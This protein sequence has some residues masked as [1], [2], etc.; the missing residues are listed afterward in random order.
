[1]SFDACLAENKEIY[2]RSSYIGTSDG[3]A[4]KPYKTIQKAVDISDSGDVIYIFGGLYRENIVIDKQVKIVGSIDGTETTIDP[5]SDERYLI[6]ITADEVTLE[7][8]A[9]REFPRNMTSPI[10]A[11]ICLKSDNNKIIG[12]Y[13]ND[14]DTY[15]IYIAASSNDNLISNNI[16]NNTKIGIYVISS[17]T[18]DIANNNIYNCSKYAIYIESSSGNNRVFGNNIYHSDSGIYSTLSD[19]INV[20]DNTIKYSNFYSIYIN[21]C[22]NATIKYNL[23]CNSTSYGVYLSSSSCIIQNNII[24]NNTRGICIDGDDNIVTKNDIY[25]N[26]GS[27]IYIISSGDDNTLYL[28]VIDNNAISAQDYGDNQWYYMFQGN[29]WSD[30]NNIDK[31]LDGIG[32]I[33]YTKNGVNDEYPLGFFLKPP[34]KPSDPTPE[35]FETGVG[36]RITLRVY[37]EDP[38]SDDLT[39]YFYRIIDEDPVLID[40]T[41]RNPVRYVRN[42]SYVECKFTLGFNATVVWYVV[43]DDGLLQNQSD[44]FVFSTITTPPDNAPP[45]ANP[46]GPYSAKINENVQFS[47]S[48]S[49]DPD[50]EIDFYRWNFGDGSSEIIEENPTHKYLSSMEYQVTLTVIDNN[51]SSA[52]ETAIVSVSTEFNDPPVAEISIQDTAYTGENILC[53]SSGTYDPDNDL[54]TYNWSFGNSET[55]NEASP[56]IVYSKKGSYVIELVVSDGEYSDSAQKVITIKE[57][58]SGLI[59]GFEILTLF[60]GLVIAIFIIK[61]RNG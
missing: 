59:P 54:L 51:G 23:I 43:V 42:D 30:Y 27:G 11:L 58:E 33:A 55:S 3:S 35:D 61:K 47:S 15:G 26:T 39:V 21:K 38:D 24:F 17:A 1:M 45:I 10:G 48:G 13:I 6:E 44:F 20:S 25:D 19:N 2:V 28:N 5:S 12:N 8:V 7:N 49:Y 46:N 36:L 53:D 22:D 37:V 32:D 34:K 29:Y 56:N 50:G 9:V 16:M 31:D 41:T 57:K 40:G 52:S 18:N 4:E 14:T 60:L